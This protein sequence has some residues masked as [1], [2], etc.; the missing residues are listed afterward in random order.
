MTKEGFSFDKM[1]TILIEA[2]PEEAAPVITRLSRETKKDPFIILVGTLLSLR[3]KDETTEKVMGM[4]MPVIKTS[5]DL[6]DMPLD[7]L[8][9]LIY[10]VGFYR[11]KAKVLKEVASEI[12]TRYGSR[13]PDTIEELLTI[14]GVGRKTANLVVTEG[15]GK[16]G[17]CVDTHVHRIS[18][19]LG[20]VSTKNPIQTED[21]LRKILP[22]QYWI[23]YNA[24][25]VTFGKR[26]C[27]PL[28][29]KC[30]QCPIESL[31]EKV[32]VTRSR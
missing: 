4:L 10:P 16:P 18:N 27:T 23:I 9:K 20:I 25:L 14:R 1:M 3:T 32:G 12:I 26:I 21:A 7:E 28:S 8:E 15:Y 11:N 29:P 13:V 6:I 31:C 2:F 19:R 5:Q 17:I 24:L 30:S 22:Q